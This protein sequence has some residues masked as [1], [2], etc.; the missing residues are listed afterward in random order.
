MAG[1]MQRLQGELRK[2][3]GAGKDEFHEG[4]GLPGTLG[5]AAW[6]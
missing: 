5:P 1:L 3:R 2:H 6:G 4:L